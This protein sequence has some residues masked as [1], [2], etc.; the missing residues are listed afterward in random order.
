MWDSQLL[1]DR[2]PRTTGARKELDQSIRDLTTAIEKQ[3]KDG[4][5]YYERGLL[6]AETGKFDEARKDLEKAY[7]LK[8]SLKVRTERKGE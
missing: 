5:L 4:Q 2:P 7:L 6:Y 8:P 1:A 3:P